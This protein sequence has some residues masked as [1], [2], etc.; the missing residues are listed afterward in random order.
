MCV[1]VCV[2]TEMQV[3]SPDEPVFY[4]FGKI[5]KCYQRFGADNHILTEQVLAFAVTQ[6]TTLKFYRFILLSRKVLQ[7]TIRVSGIT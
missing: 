1:C 6:K 2:C 7:L 5:P 4:T 3:R